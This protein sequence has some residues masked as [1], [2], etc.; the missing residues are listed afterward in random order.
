MA[1]RNRRIIAPFEK[2]NQRR[3]LAFKRIHHPAIL[4]MDRPRAFDSAI[5][6]PFGQP[7]IKRQ[8][9]C[10]DA[11]FVKSE[12]AFRTASQKKIIGIL[13]AFGDGFKR[14]QSAYVILR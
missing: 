11:L 6:Q 8:V 12:D 1:G 2:L 14:I 10:F 4:A 7:K 13:N 5:S 9:F 3:R